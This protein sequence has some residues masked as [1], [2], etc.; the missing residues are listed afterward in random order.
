MKI[1]KNITKFH[2]TDNY[3]SHNST[4]VLTIPYF[5]L[6]ARTVIELQS[7]STNFK[8][9]LATYTK[10]TNIRYL[11]PILQAVS[12]FNCLFIFAI[13]RVCVLMF[14]TALSIPCM[15][16][17]SQILNSVF[18]DPWCHLEKS[19]CCSTLSR[20]I[21]IYISNFL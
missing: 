20:A 10:S 21:L 19:M 4:V 8:L 12:L 15:A 17:Y 3:Y 13:N 16:G 1:S 2:L 9:G 5:L 7:Y 11:K 14:Q 6:K 18:P